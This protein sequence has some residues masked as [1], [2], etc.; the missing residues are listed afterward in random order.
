MTINSGYPLHPSAE[1]R[2]AKQSQLPDKARLGQVAQTRRY[3]A[4]PSRLE[5]SRQRELTIDD[6]RPPVGQSP[7]FASAGAGIAMRGS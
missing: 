1:R 4:A 2:Q 6:A 3:F 7:L 5:A